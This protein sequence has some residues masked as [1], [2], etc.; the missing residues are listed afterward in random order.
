MIKV[1]PV[2]AGLLMEPPSVGGPAMV[3]CSPFV[4]PTEGWALLVSRATTADRRPGNCRWGRGVVAADYRG[5]D[6]LSAV[7]VAKV[8]PSMAPGR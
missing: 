5:V 4:P 1:F 7:G 2:P 3:L 6:V 8:G